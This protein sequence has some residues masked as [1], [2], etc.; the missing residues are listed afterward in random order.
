MQITLLVEGTRRAATREGAV[1]ALFCTAGISCLGAVDGIETSRLL[2]WV[3]KLLSGLLG[4]FGR[5]SPVSVGAILLLWE[6]WQICF[7]W[8]SRP[9]SNCPS[10][11]LFLILFAFTL[12]LKT[13]YRLRRSPR[14][15]APLLAGNIFMVL[16]VVLS[17]R[18][19]EGDGLG[20]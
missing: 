3:A 18:S 12:R 19:S 20:V 6:C 9:G 15:G 5:D 2:E 14:A 13:G 8:R 7:L 16:V 10:L 17:G 11:L 4:L 1:A